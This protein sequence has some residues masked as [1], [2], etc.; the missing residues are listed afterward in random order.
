[1]THVNLHG[2]KLLVAALGFSLHTS[3]LLLHDHVLLPQH[4]LRPARLLLLHLQLLQL[5]L[6]GP[7][8][9]RLVDLG[10]DGDLLAAVLDGD[11][12]LGF[13][14]VPHEP[15]HGDP[16]RHG[17]LGTEGGE[18]GEKVRGQGVRGQGSG[19]VRGQRSTREDKVKKRTQM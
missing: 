10:H 16:H 2:L 1:M 9:Q 12:T 18:R 6:V 3:Q 4:G 15:Q 11:G 14:Q 13:R 8:A 7:L 5:P 19:G 17:R